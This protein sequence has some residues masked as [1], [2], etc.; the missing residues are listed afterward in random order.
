MRWPADPVA[1]RLS[2]FVPVHHLSP[3]QD[4]FASKGYRDAGYVYINSDDC[5]WALATAIS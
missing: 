1:R 4:V 3:H 2:W 5:A